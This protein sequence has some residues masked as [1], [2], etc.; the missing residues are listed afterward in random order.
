MMDNRFWRQG[1]LVAERI[2]GLNRRGSRWCAGVSAVRAEWKAGR[3]LAAGAGA[4][5]AVRQAPGSGELAA[6]GVCACTA[7]NSQ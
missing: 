1:D 3:G 4:G 7:G 5:V 2:R 6:G